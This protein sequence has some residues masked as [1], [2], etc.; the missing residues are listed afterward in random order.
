MVVVVVG[1]RDKTYPS[2]TAIAR[3][4]PGGFKPMPAAWTQDDALYPIR[5]AVIGGIQMCSLLY[6]RDM[7]NA[8]TKGL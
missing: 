2:P 6:E 7:E 5:T 8:E 4:Y 3:A 1:G